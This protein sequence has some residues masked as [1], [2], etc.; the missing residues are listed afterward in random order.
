MSSK[1]YCDCCGV[2]ITDAN[3]ARGGAAR[4]P[5]SDWRLGGKVGRLSIEVMTG[6]DGVWNAGHVCRYCIIDAVKSFDDRA[7]AEALAAPVGWISVSER[8]PRQYE[9]VLVCGLDGP[10]IPSFCSDGASGLVWHD[11]DV[12]RAPLHGIT[13]WMPLPAPPNAAPPGAPVA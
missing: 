10:V 6:I 8:L 9:T 13:H 5:V 12:G 7:L 1:H 11:H 4:N 3:N 2:E